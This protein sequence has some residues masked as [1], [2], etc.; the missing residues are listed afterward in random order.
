MKPP[1]PTRLG[2]V[3]WRQPSPDYLLEDAAGAARPETRYE[4]AEATSL[5][6]ITALR[7]LPPRQVAV[8]MMPGT[9]P[10]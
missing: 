6:F 7:V 2:E 1:E 10:S 3:G 9:T 8:L 4:Q 5:A